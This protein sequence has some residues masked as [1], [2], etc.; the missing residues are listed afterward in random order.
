MDDIAWLIFVDVATLAPLLEDDSKLVE[1][2]CVALIEALYEVECG[3]RIVLAE[4][5]V[6]HGA[7]HIKA[8]ECAQFLRTEQPVGTT[9]R[10]KLEVERRPETGD[11][12]LRL[13]AHV[14]VQI[15]PRGVRELLAHFDLDDVHRDTTLRRVE[16]HDEEVRASL[17]QYLARSTGG[18]RVEPA[19]VSVE[20]EDEPIAEQPGLL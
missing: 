20:G 5:A 13:C 17:G 19:W 10:I 1:I 7:A 18:V 8:E 16:P 2:E 12:V 4:E 15:Q 3:R 9:I 11:R 14:F 6:T